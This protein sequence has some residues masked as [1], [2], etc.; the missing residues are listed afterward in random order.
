MITEDKF[1]DKFDLMQLQSADTECKFGEKYG[2]YK[3]HE[4][5]VA[6]IQ[7]EMKKLQK[8]MKEIK[9]WVHTNEKQLDS[10]F[11]TDDDYMGDQTTDEKTKTDVTYLLG[12]IHEYNEKNPVVFT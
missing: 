6:E 5:E 8:R 11:E 12:M 2:L 4:K 1:V 10:V 7:L 3:F 9:D